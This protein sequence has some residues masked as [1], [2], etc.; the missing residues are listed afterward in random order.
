MQDA[1]S[2]LS[3]IR[4][5][6]ALLQIDDVLDNIYPRTFA[7]LTFILSGASLAACYILIANV[8]NLDCDDKFDQ[9]QS[10]SLQSDTLASVNFWA[11]LA[12]PIT[13]MGW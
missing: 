7:T 2:L 10:A 1:G 12:L 8:A 5:S 4:T 3:T 6:V 9:W 13:T 11:C